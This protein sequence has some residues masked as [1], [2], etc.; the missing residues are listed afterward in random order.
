MVEIPDTSEKFIG[1]ASFIRRLLKMLE[2]IRGTLCYFF[3]LLA[4]F[5]VLVDVARFTSINSKKV[6]IEVEVLAHK[7]YSENSRAWNF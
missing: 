5:L 6:E 7:L 4:T 3:I 1:S 2:R